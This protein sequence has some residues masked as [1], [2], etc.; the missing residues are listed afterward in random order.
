MSNFG[1][2]ADSDWLMFCLAETPL[3]VHLFL[4][5]WWLVKVTTQKPNCSKNRYHPA[6]FHGT[7][8]ETCNGSALCVFLFAFFFFCIGRLERA[9]FEAFSVL[10]ASPCG[11]RECVEAKCWVFPPVMFF[12]G[13]YLLPVVNANW[14][15]EKKLM[16]FVEKQKKKQN[17]ITMQ[18]VLSHPSNA[19]SV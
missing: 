5:R 19:W 6:L 9:R 14:I 12:F 4:V 7:K 15:C 17:K 11:L 1:F 13:C 16:V 2:S 8:I 10:K 3:V 18:S